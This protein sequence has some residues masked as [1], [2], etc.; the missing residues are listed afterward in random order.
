MFIDNSGEDRRDEQV[1]NNGIEP[2]TADA[3]SFRSI[4]R[5][6]ACAKEGA[7]LDSNEHHGSQD[8][9]E[10]EKKNVSQAILATNIVVIEAVDRDRVNHV[11]QQEER[12]IAQRKDHFVC[13]KCF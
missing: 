2:N 10:C 1:N 6:E 9:E 5:Q 7:I 8:V 11:I 4:P 12:Q 13:F 3:L